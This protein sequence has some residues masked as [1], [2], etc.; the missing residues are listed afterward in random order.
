MTYTAKGD[1][2]DAGLSGGDKALIDRYS[3]EWAAANAAG[4]EAGKAAAH[5]KAE[6]VRANYGYSGGDDGSERLAMTAEQMAQ[7]TQRQDALLDEY[8]GL[9]ESQNSA[10]QQ[11]LAQQRAA[12]A[13]AAQTAVNTLEGSKTETD[14]QYAD[15]FRQLYIDK[16]KNRKNLNQRLA[17]SGITGGA[18]ESTALGY[19]TAYED[20]LR[21]GEQGR[22]DA[23]NDID[24]AI[25]DARLTG[26]LES[27][28]AAADAVKEQTDAYADALKY[29][30]DR[31]DTMNARQA[32]YE[33]ETA[34]A[35]RSYAYKTAMQLINSG[36]MPGAA[37][38]ERAGIDS[39][40]ARSLVDA[41]NEE[42]TKADG[43]PTLTAA[44]VN[45]AIKAGLLTDAVLEAYEY[46]YKAPY[47]G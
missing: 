45:A 16:M 27:A 8:R 30:I 26:D 40:T 5:A 33:R 28:R 3:A 17:A 14:R 1:Y 10:Y 11:M 47:R 38:L 22:I 24:R 4:D 32:E 34:A 7:Q 2:F 42:K 44:Q 6:A 13:A 9:Y 35:N 25:A 31:Q 46:Y 20:A 43:K 21:R 23:M 29:L 12:Q 37:L 36:A 41:V 18:A 39:E 15:L 19:D